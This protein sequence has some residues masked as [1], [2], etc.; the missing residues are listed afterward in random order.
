MAPQI[1]KF[2]AA[3]MATL[4]A[5]LVLTSCDSQIFDYE[6]DCSATHHLKFKYDMNMKFADAFY[7]EVTEVRLF[8]PHEDIERCRDIARSVG[9]TFRLREKQ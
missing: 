8:V 2:G 9:A 3:L 1:R 7:N 4:F 6:G 5:G